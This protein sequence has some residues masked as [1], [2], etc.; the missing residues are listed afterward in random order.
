MCVCVCQ[1]S[2]LEFQLWS[3]YDGQP[4]QQEESDDGEEKSSSCCV[5]KALVDVSALACGLP[6]ISGWYHVYSLTGQVQGQLK[7]C[8]CIG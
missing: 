3:K 1:C 2:G 4:P 5:G 8:Y 6:H 7:V